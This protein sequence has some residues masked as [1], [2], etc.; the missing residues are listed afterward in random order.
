MFDSASTNTTPQFDRAEFVG[1]SGDK[2]HFCQ[3]VISQQY[4]RVGGVMACGTCAEIA[5][6]RTPVDSH[7]GYVR[8]LSFGIG[9]GVVGLVVYAAFGI[10][11]GWVIGYLSLGVGYI[12]GKAMMFGSKGI[13][14]RRY[15]ITAVLLTYAAVSMAAVPIG[16]SQMSKEKAKTQQEQL[17]D[18]QAQFEKENGQQPQSPAS[19]PSAP[20]MSMAAALGS[21]ALLGLASPFLELQSPV[22]GLIGLVIL[23]V[24]IQIA[25]KITA[26]R[27]ALNIEGPFDT[28]PSKPLLPSS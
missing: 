7:S 6:H 3:Q 22:H 24:G 23:Y 16:I 19:Q 28:T 8:A 21:L 10:L 25:W 17:Q 1:T 18:E 12:V 5:R 11:T 9:A 2:C 26:G 4:F 13:G 27:T 14:G 15:Q 20:K